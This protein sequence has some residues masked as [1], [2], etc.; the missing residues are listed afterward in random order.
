MHRG[1]ILVP[2]VPERAD[3]FL[4]LA[5]QALDLLSEWDARRFLRVQRY[6][7]M[8]VDGRG[9][10][11]WYRFPLRS[12]E[13]DIGALPE[14][15]Y[16][17]RRATYLAA[18][19]VH[20]ASH[21]LI[22]AHTARGES[23]NFFNACERLCFLEQARFLRH[24]PDGEQLSKHYLQLSKEYTCDIA[25]LEKRRRKLHLWHRRKTELEKQAQHSL[26]PRV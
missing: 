26:S 20:E 3:K 23:L 8:L 18:A 17:V 19:L 11:T 14:N 15:T 12:V 13:T 4:K 16:G 2:E 5:M 9:G 21:G 24:A 6:V 22:Y 10:G 25:Y 1:V 7:R